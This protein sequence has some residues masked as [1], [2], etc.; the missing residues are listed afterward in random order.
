MPTTDEMILEALDAPNTRILVVVFNADPCYKWSDLAVLKAIEKDKAYDPPL[1]LDCFLYLGLNPHTVWDPEDQ[2]H[3]AL[4]WAVRTGSPDCVALLLCAGAD[5]NGAKV[6]ETNSWTM[7][8]ELLP[9]LI[10]L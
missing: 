5:P 10:R 1:Y 4:M 9:M 8:L 6:R 7:Q 2:H 3:D